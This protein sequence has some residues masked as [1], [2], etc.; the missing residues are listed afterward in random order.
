MA[1]DQIGE[2]IPTRVSYEGV[3]LWPQQEE[4]HAYRGLLVVPSYDLESGCFFD[5]EIWH[6]ASG[7]DVLVVR[8][9]FER[10]LEIA[11]H[12]AEIMDWRAIEKPD[13]K[14]LRSQLLGFALAYPTEVLSVNQWLLETEDDLDSIVPFG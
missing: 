9:P 4:G 10:T 12:L 8:A 3:R 6:Q 14:A 1:T 13:A 5:W 11:V 7:A 2:W